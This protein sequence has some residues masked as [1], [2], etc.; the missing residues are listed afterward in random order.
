MPIGQTQAKSNKIPKPI[1]ANHKNGR[2]VN[3]RKASKNKGKN[4]KAGKKNISSELNQN[5][6]FTKLQKLSLIEFVG[7][8]N[9]SLPVV[10][11]GARLVL[12]D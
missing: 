7:A 4:I 10:Y 2:L 6:I 11:L 9:R 5:T 3:K 12:S 1:S 8:D